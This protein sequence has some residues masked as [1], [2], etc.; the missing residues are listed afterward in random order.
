MSSVDVDVDVEDTRAA[1]PSIRNTASGKLAHVP[2]HQLQVRTRTETFN[3]GRRTRV[4][5]SPAM[6]M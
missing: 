2:V 1:T 5:V 6:S 3:V 4:I